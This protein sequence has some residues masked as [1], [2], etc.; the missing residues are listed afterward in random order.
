MRHSKTGIS[1]T[2]LMTVRSMLIPLDIRARDANPRF[3]VTCDPKL[4]EHVKKQQRRQKRNY[5]ERHAVRDTQLLPGQH[6]YCTSAETCSPTSLS[7]LEGSAGNSC[8]RITLVRSPKEWLPPFILRCRAVP[9][10][11]ARR[12][13]AFARRYTPTTPCDSK[14]EN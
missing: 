8:D 11:V 6:I 4:R 3:Y 12:S 10:P 14:F 9:R 5:D 7:S 13:K 2:E 1:H